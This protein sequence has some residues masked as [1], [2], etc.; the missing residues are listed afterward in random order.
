MKSKRNEFKY[1]FEEKN[2]MK[3]FHE[4]VPNPK[5]KYEFELDTFQKQA[6]Y[7]MELGEHVFVIAHTSAG[8][9]ATAEYAIAMAQQKGMKAIYTSPIKALSNQK[10]YDF[11]KVFGKVGIITGD[12]RIESDDDIVKIMT[13]EI[14]RSKL[15]QDM[16]FIDDVDWVIFDEVHYV[17]DEER[18]VVWE[19]VIMS[20]PKH[21]KLLMLSATVENAMNFA[22]WI[23]RTKNQR[24]CIVKTLYRPVPLE[25]FVYKKKKKSKEEKLITFKV[26]ENKFINQQTTITS[27]TT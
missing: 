16:K 19:E 6:I 24:V 2:D 11:R 12:V 22:E 7:H 5:R 15:Y 27:F 23:G 3:K 20:V 17:N 10:Y 14:L 25:H 13:T 18:G 1:A 26:G 21:V 4:L 8:K 9:T